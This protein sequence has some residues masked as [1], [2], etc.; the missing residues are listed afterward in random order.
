MRSSSSIQNNIQSREMVMQHPTSCTG[1]IT[2]PCKKRRSCKKVALSSTFNH[3]KGALHKNV[4][5]CATEE[6]Y[7]YCEVQLQLQ[8]SRGWQIE[9]SE[10]CI[11]I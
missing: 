6:D 8:E 5:P 7:N 11:D 9:P 3:Q 10:G 1:C 4:M 2:I